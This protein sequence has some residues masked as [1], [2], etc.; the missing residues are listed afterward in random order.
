MGDREGPPDTGLSGDG[1]RTEALSQ[2]RE[3]PPVGVTLGATGKLV[4]PQQD[5]AKERERVLGSVSG[6][7]KEAEG[8]RPISLDSS[9]E[10]PGSPPI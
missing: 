6:D 2:E 8:Q 1:Y 4:G 5:A 10:A 9:T 7:S 3:P